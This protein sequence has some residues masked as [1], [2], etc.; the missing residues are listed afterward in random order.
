MVDVGYTFKIKLSYD[1]LNTMTELSVWTCPVVNGTSQYMVVHYAGNNLAGAGVE[2]Y[3]TL[4]NDGNNKFFVDLV[5]NA[6]S[7]N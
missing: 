2:W 5:K 6:S 3:L 7:V 4:F 1:T